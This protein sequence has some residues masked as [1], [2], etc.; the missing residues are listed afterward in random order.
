[1]PNLMYFS[2]E[3]SKAEDISAITACPDLTDLRFVD[4]YSILDYAPVGELRHLVSLT[5]YVGGFEEYKMPSL[6]GL[7]ELESLSLGDLEDLSLL[8]EVSGITKLT[9]EDCYAEELPELTGLPLEE[10]SLDGTYVNG[11]GDLNDIF[12]IPTLQVLDLDYFS[13]KLDL[14]KLP[15]N[16]SLRQLSMDRT[17]FRAGSGWGE[18]QLLSDHYDLFRHFPNLEYLTVRSMEID[19]IDFVQYLPKLR[20]LDITDNHVSS[21]KPLEQLEDFH[22]VLCGMNEI[23][24]SV[25][26]ESGIYVDTESW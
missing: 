17:A 21:L 16:G 1:M 13:G 5:I 12:G 23:E 20:Y 25:S 24:E 2:V 6:K 11:G 19:R 15:D 4:N 10:L 22:T 8:S 9:L 26:E 3:G 18:E 14:Y 7:T